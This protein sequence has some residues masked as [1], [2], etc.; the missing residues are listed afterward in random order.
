[1]DHNSNLILT[2]Q[3]G[4]ARPQGTDGDIGSVELESVVLACTPP[5]LGLL[6]WWTGDG[7]TTDIVGGY[8]GTLTSGASYIVGK[9]AQAFSFDGSTGQVSLT[10]EPS[11]TNFTIAGWV[12]ISQYTSG[13]SWPYQTIYTDNSHGF[14]LKDGYINWWGP[15]TDRFLGTQQVPLNTW[16]HIVLTYSGGTFTGYVNGVLGGT[17]VFGGESLPTGVVGI[18]GHS[19]EHLNGDIDELQIFNRALSQSEIQTIVNAGSVGQCK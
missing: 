16:T 10:T 13:G 6:A 9:V 5:A 8:N 1:M 17:S 7:N 2:D 19:L 11:A 14:W 18:G 15:S 12:Q 3:R 4:I